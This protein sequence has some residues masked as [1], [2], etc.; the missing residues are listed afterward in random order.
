MMRQKYIKIIAPYKKL[1]ITL[2]SS[3]LIILYLFISEIDI[4]SPGHGVITGQNDKVVIKS[5]SSGFINS[6]NLKEGDL[7][8]K[9]DMLFSYTNLDFTYKGLILKD[10][11]DF[12]VKKIE[13]FKK[14]SALLESL[15][16]NEAKE[17]KNN[18]IMTENDNL[19]DLL[20]YHSFKLEKESL[21][22]EELKLQEKE[23]LLNDE[24][25]LREGKINNLHK[26]G[27]LLKN[28]GASDIEILSNTVDLDQQRTD[29]INVKIN[30]LKLKTD[31]YN[32]K[33]RFYVKL[34]EQIYS[35]KDK[36]S[37]LERSNIE[38][39]GELKL[40]NDKVSTNSVTSPFS[41]T[42]LKIEN[43]MKEGS[44]IEQYQPVVTLKQDNAGQVIEAKFDTRY[45]PYLYEGALVKISVNSTAFKK[46]FN[47]RISRI[48]S[49][50]F[51]D[52]A[53]QGKES[54]YY[55][56]TIDAIDKTEQRPLPEGIEVNVFAISNKVSVFDYIISSLKSNLVFN[57]W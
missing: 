10:I 40:M 38:N 37:E 46:N 47:G 29:L 43:N 4:V 55:S 56:V 54:R 8:E 3:I 13:M 14:D 2:I 48:S 1:I 51:L 42:V 39:M 30:F 7:I 53:R 20:S 36:I 44:F 6:F 16:R 34:S 25:K 23:I 9:G 50:S 31:F 19:I 33:S 57:V 18:N 15:Q 22:E 32:T 12:N 52:N 24:I 49:D 28:G 11:I 5:P 35:I 17:I 21:E 45:R 27:T 26:K 41:G